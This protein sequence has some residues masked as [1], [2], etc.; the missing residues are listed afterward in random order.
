MK[1][2]RLTIAGLMLIVAMAAIVSAR[3][4][5][6]WYEARGAAATIIEH[7]SDGVKRFEGPGEDG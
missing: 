7:Y 3:I 4:V 2:P 6:A 5:A 1:L